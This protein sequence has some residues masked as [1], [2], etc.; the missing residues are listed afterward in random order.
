MPID[1][2]KDHTLGFPGE[3]EPLEPMIDSDEYSTDS[4]MSDSD[5]ETQSGDW[6]TKKAGSDLGYNPEDY[7]DI[8]STEERAL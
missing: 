2:S 7:S 6:K 3:H 1:G 5:D 4:E 8:D